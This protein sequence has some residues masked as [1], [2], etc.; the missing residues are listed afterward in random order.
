MYRVVH[1]PGLSHER[2]VRTRIFVF[3]D[4]AARWLAALP[5]LRGEKDFRRHV[6]AYEEAFQKK[7]VPPLEPLWYPELLGSH[8]PHLQAI[9]EELG[10]P[11]YASLHRWSVERRA[12]FWG[13]LLQRLRIPFERP[14]VQILAFPE[15]DITQPRWLTGAVWNSVEALFWADPQS[16]ALVFYPI[17]GSPRAWTYEELR[18]EVRQV[19]GALYTQGLQPGQ[20][21]ALLLAHAARGSLSVLRGLVRWCYG[22]YHPR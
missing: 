19:A 14:P 22:G 6:E 9:L 8:K 11:S 16:I 13:Y 4:G 21:V 10:H 1:N 17:A 7:A 5:A 18:M 3:M 20:T 12:E 15:G 2:K